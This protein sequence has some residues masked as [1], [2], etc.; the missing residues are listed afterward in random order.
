MITVSVGSAGCVVFSAFFCTAAL[1]ANAS[2]VEQTT[3]ERV[4]AAK[5]ES[6]TARRDNVTMAWIT[7]A[8]R[9]HWATRRGA[10]RRADE[11]D[12]RIHHARLL[13]RRVSAETLTE[14]GETRDQ[15]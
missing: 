15:R 7:S 13:L 4:R 3:S 12:G 6:D 1:C 5:A 2:S 8:P 10:C 9:S 14:T 11:G